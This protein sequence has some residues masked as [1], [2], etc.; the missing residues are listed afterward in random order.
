MKAIGVENEMKRK[1]FSLLPSLRTIYTFLLYTTFHLKMFDVCSLTLLLN[2]ETV[3]DS[4]DVF[5][6][7]T[8]HK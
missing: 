5:Y 8:I 3:D 7:P 4:F 6:A 2:V 1:Y